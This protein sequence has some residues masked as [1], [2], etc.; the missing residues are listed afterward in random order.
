MLVTH[1]IPATRAAVAT[2]RRTGLR[3]GL[4]PTMGYLHAGHLALLAAARRDQTW[5]VVSIFV[6]PTQFGP[7]EDFDRYPRDTAG[8][9]AQCAAAGCELVFLPA[10]ADMYRPDAVTTVHVAQLTDT[11]CGPLRPGH[12][13]GVATV[14]S[15]LFNIIQPDVAYFG[16]KDAQQLVV[17]RRLVRDLDFPLTIVGEPTVREPD[18]LALSS[19]NALLAPDERARAVVLIRALRAG[20]QLIREQRATDAA[21]VLRAMRA[22]VAEGRPAAVD[23]ISIVDPATLQP[24]TQITGPV[25][26]AL[27]VRIGQTRLIDNLLV[28]PSRR[29][30]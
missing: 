19:R 29:S 8:D 10:V 26:I 22:V 28:D 3:I 30:G 6:N 16:Q 14:V 7:N 20:E 11:L 9:L 4:V 5:P 17:I 18:G 23:Y 27:A 25:L 1:D 24:V 2:A 15:K 12:F 13:D 21:A